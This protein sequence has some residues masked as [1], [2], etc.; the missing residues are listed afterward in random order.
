MKNY[1]Q[2]L[3]RFIPWAV[4]LASLL[5]LNLLE[6]F[7]R[8]QTKDGVHLQVWTS[9]DMMQTL[10]IKQLRKTPVQSLWYLHKQPPMLDFIRSVTAQ[11]LRDIP[12]EYL[13]L[14]EDRL[15]YCVWSVFFAAMAS[16]VYI[17]LRRLTNIPFALFATFMWVIHPAPIVYSM[18][19]EGTLMSSLL[20]LWFFYEFWD[21]D[22][23]RGSVFRVT[24]ISAL[25][26][27]T[28]VAFQWYFFPVLLVSLALK[29][30]SLRRL[31]IFSALSFVLVFPYVI[32]QYALFGTTSST[33]FAGYHKCG[34]LWYQPSQDE[35]NGIKASL[36]FKYPQKAVIY[37]GGDRYNTRD[38]C[39]D[40][41]AYTEAFRRQLKSDPRGS[42]KQ[43]LRS[44]KANFKVYWE[45]SSL[46]GNNI[47]V[48]GLFWTKR[49]NSI[50]SRYAFT[51]LLIFAFLIWAYFN[52]K[53]KGWPSRI[54]G[55]IG[56][57]IPAAY[58]FLN[59]NLSNRCYWIE[60]NR[61]KF[62]LEP[63]FYI[64]ITSQ[65]FCLFKQCFLRKGRTG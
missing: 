11:F 24:L 56:L 59:S 42:F 1:P 17:W 58:I 23:N 47:Y 10:P 57:F 38:Q 34:I 27:Y 55:H 28:R 13:L 54:S 4:F 46:Y 6:D 37:S 29:K 21:I 15:L 48:G 8:P 43:V 18:L 63:V 14:R 3:I 9:D 12:D 19:L 53:R 25:L 60:A 30:V 33:T 51:G 40:N 50:F 44:F 65:I 41:L 36:R 35:I 31:V 49:Y 26:F 62:Y 45:A 20:I 64:F 5:F 61:L 52:V 7:Y 32:K 16:I 39:L 2:S 22:R